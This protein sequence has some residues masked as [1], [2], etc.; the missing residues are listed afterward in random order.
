[1]KSNGEREK[2]R[3]WQV[4]QQVASNLIVVAGGIV[5]YLTLN[6]LDVVSD[7][8]G[9]LMSILSPFM[10]GLVLAYLLDGLARFFQQKLL[11]GKHRTFAVILAYLVTLLLLGLLLRIVLPQVVQTPST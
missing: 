10:A 6:N 1:M 7:A 2:E 9:E 4:T 3:K 5:L 8:L 11:G